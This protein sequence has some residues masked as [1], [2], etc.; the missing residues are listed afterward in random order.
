VENRLRPDL[1][2]SSVFI[3]AARKGLRAAR[4]NLPPMLVLQGAMAAIVAVY[5]TWPRG[6]WV[7]ARFGAWQH[8][9]GVIAAACATAFA[10]GILSETSAV[11][12]QNGGKWT[13]AHLENMAFKVALF[14]VSGAIVYE[15][16][17]Q[18]AVWFGHGAS[19]SVLVPKVLVDQFVYTVVW[20]VPYQT[21]L[22]RWQTLGFSFRRLGEEMRE[23]FLTARL[24]PVLVTNWMFWIP[25]VS[26]IYSMPS[27]LQ[28]TL[29][30]FAT[31][32]WGLLLPAVARQ[33]HERSTGTIQDLVVPEP[34]ILS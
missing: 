18:Q 3:N 12:F 33:T 24:L 22:T 34:E 15:F 7:L 26:L 20:A 6:A 10:G 27:I 5:Y 28:T 21:L 2:S 17:Q 31:A 11:Y 13:Q 4:A 29:F 16:Y 1:A 9:G 25:G 23:D 14:F 32:I 8:A 19:W 30:I